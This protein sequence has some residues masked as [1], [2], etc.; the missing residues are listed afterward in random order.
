MYDP[1][2]VAFTVTRFALPE[3]KYTLQKSYVNN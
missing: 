3:I 2:E 1:S